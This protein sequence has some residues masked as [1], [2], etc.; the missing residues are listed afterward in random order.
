MKIIC[1]DGSPPKLIPI[2]STLPTMAA[3]SHRTT[4]SKFDLDLD[5]EIY[6]VASLIFHSI[7]LSPYSNRS[8]IFDQLKRDTSRLF[9]ASSISPSARA[10]PLVRYFPKTQRDLVRKYL[11]SITDAI[12]INPRAPDLPPFPFVSVLD[13]SYRKTAVDA[14]LTIAEKTHHTD[15]DSL[16]A[17]LTVILN[18][19]LDFPHVFDHLT[20]KPFAQQLAQ[21]LFHV[22]A[23]KHGLGSFFQETA[24]P[25]ALS[26]IHSILQR[27]PVPTALDAASTS[28]PSFL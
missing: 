17:S 6:Q 3:A 16:R 5:R 26:I 18:L 15:I 4:T 7:P 28:T 14:L 25:K 13:T 9:N 12:D 24:L 19:I 21:V 23:T 2:P 22:T 10:T 27:K 8:R 1:V 20:I 11:I